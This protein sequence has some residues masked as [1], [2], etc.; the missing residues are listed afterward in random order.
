MKHAGW[1]KFSPPAKGSNFQPAPIPMLVRLKVRCELVS[2]DQRCAA[3]FD[4]LGSS[5]ESA[6]L[7]NEVSSRAG[8][9]SDVKKKNIL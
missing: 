8:T 1:A 5:G 2:S 4:G 9:Y 3:Q 6:Y 7:A